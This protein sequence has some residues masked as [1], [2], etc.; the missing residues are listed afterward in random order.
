EQRGQAALDVGRDLLERRLLAAE[1]DSLSL[2]VEGE[3][4][5]EVDRDRQRVRQAAV[6]RREPHV[7]RL[8]LHRDLDAGERTH[9]ARPDARAT[10]DRVGG[11]PALARLDGLD[12]AV[13]VDLDAGRL[14]A[15]DDAQAAG[16][17]LDD[18]L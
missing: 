3:A 17:P 4:R 2:A 13:A 11:A 14:A 5:R 12:P 18:R 6:L 8:A 7:A 10:D 9:L 16:V 15:L 1:S